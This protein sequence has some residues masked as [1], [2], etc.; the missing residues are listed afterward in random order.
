MGR[1]GGANNH[2]CHHSKC[3]ARVRA[4]TAK[5]STNSLQFSFSALYGEAIEIKLSCHAAWYLA[6]CPS[7]GWVNQRHE[8]RTSVDHDDVEAYLGPVRPARI[9]PPPSLAHVAA[10]TDRRR[11]LAGAQG[12]PVSGCSASECQRRDGA[13]AGGRRDIEEGNALTPNGVVPTAPGMAL[14]LRSHTC[15]PDLNGP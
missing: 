12:W 1:Q 14:A 2:T 6:A 5:E 9:P 7:Q 8:C 3:P 4:M 15:A 13:W 10:N 11:Q